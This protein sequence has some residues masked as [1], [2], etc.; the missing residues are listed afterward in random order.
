MASFTLC[1]GTVVEYVPI[2]EPTECSEC[3]HVTGERITNEPAHH[4]ETVKRD[5]KYYCSRCGERF[6]DLALVAA[7]TAERLLPSIRK[8]V[9]QAGPFYRM[10]RGRG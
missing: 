4:G 9:E 5:G 10:L 6:V 1:D 3:G 2:Y 7:I 8:Q